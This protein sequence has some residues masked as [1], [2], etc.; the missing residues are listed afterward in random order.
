MVVIA[1]VEGSFDRP[2]LLC[3][4]TT[5]Q[6]PSQDLFLHCNLERVKTL[7]DR[8]KQIQPTLHHRAAQSASA[9]PV[10]SSNASRSAAIPLDGIR[11]RL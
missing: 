4:F 6:K 1:K 8:A 2:V 10:H 7:M 5:A 9:D 3:E 11:A